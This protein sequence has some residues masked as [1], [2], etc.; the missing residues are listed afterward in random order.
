MKFKN[1]KM[2]TTILSIASTEEMAASMQELNNTIS[3]LSDSSRN[4]NEIAEK[5][6]KDLDV[7]RL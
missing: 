6:Q 2:R 5:P 7:F 4:L 1:L 3:R